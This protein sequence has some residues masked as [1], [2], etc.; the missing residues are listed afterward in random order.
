MVEPLRPKPGVM[1][2][3]EIEKASSRSD[4][5]ALSARLTRASVELNTTFVEGGSVAFNDAELPP[6]VP[7]RIPPENT[8]VR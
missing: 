4:P 8:A 6:E 5:R 2:E 7:L 1:P 3:N